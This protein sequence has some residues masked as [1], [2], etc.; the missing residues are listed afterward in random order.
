[1]FV[2]S[3]SKRFFH[4]SIDPNTGSD[5]RIELPSRISHCLYK[6]SYNAMFRILSGSAILSWRNKVKQSGFFIKE[7]L[8]PIP[9]LFINYA[10]VQY[11]VV[12]QYFR[13]SVGGKFPNVFRRSSTLSFVGFVLFFFVWGKKFGSVWLFNIAF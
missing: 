10:I 2:F 3:T 12:S 5:V 1:M 13:F 6:V 7:T 8:C 11:S 9:G 4:G